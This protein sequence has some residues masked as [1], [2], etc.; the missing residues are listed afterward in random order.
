MG[1]VPFVTA[2]MSPLFSWVAKVS[3]SNLIHYTGVMVQVQGAMTHS[4]LHHTWVTAQPV[5][6]AVSIGQEE[7]NYMQ[8][9]TNSGGNMLMLVLVLGAFVLL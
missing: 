5:Y 1:D 6:S 3:S 2:K 8:L 9:C 7:K 4:L